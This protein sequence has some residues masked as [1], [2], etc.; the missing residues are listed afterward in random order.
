[1]SHYREKGQLIK[2]EFSL[3]LQPL[4]CSDKT[5]GKIGKKIAKT[6]ILSLIKQKFAIKC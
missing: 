3:G 4:Y 1:M 2:F 5:G 6:T